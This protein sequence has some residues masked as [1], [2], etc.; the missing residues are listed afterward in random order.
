MS[1]RFASLGSMI[2]RAASL[3][4]TVLLRL[5]ATVLLAALPMAAAAGCAPARTPPSGLEA[6]PR[7]QPGAPPPPAPPP[8]DPIRLP[9]GF[10]PEGIA[11]DPDGIVYLGERNTGEI[12]RYEL[13][14]GQGRLVSP[15][16][17]TPAQGMK[18]DD[19]GRLFVAGRY[20]GDA[21]VVDTRTGA[22]LAGYRLFD[23]PTKDNNLVN[24]VL[25]TADAWWLTDSRNPVL[26]RLPL[27]PDGALPTQA[28]VRK[29]PISG[30]MV[31]RRGINANGIATTPDGGALLVVQ[32]NTGGLFRID[33]ATGVST[34]VDL[35]G[36]TL[37]DGDGLL[38]QNRT[39]YVVQN[40]SATLTVVEL[41]ETASR[42]TVR[43]RV[44]DPRFD[45]PTTVAERGGRLY[46]PN[47]RFDAPGAST[48]SMVI[49][50]E[51]VVIP[52]PG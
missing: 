50:H 49:R 35:G 30:A 9:D 16:T 26:Y 32:S 23:N 31:Y 15:P 39:L 24:D 37:A 1:D 47:A 40:R 44:T 42:G 14:T 3:R 41:D 19:A 21:R 28:E 7:S 11:I 46:L 20:A 8:I 10:A 18:V 51:V 22:V 2:A 43:A 52:R 45:D 48:D 29:I 13:A 5:L 17:G 27:R 33:P 38:R 12:Y 25:L 6:P 4:A 36:E 34:P